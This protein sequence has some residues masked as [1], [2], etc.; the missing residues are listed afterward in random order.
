NWFLPLDRMQPRIEEYVNSHTEWKTN[1]FG[2]CQSWLTDV[3]RPR[4]M[5][6]D[7]D[8][9]IKVPLPNADGKVLYV[10]FDAP[11]GYI[12]MTKELTPDWADYWCKDAT[13]LGHF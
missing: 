13:K 12:S 11:I 4:A 5:T 2:Q 10:W 6:R 7:L 3:F 9:G 1:V 8:W